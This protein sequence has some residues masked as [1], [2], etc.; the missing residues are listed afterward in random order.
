MLNSSLATPR[1][2]ASNEALRLELLLPG[3]SCVAAIAWLAAAAMA[4]PL[5]PICCSGY[6]IASSFTSTWAAICSLGGLCAIVV[7]FRFLGS[8]FSFLLLGLE[9]GRSHSRLLFS[10]TSVI[11]LW[12]ASNSSW[13][14]SCSW[15]SL[16]RWR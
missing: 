14:F 12:S 6:D 2:I 4:D 7:F 15:S 1:L 11:P 8:L 9:E 10:R 5:L 13:N 3:T 16:R